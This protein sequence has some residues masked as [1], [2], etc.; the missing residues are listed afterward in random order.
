MEADMR[1]KVVANRQ[2]PNS[3]MIGAAQQ[4]NANDTAYL[5][6]PVLLKL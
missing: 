4:A 3:A 6:M 1:V 5:I 2:K